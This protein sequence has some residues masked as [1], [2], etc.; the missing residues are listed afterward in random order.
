MKR[1]WGNVWGFYTTGSSKEQF[2]QVSRKEHHHNKKTLKY[3]S[4]SQKALGDDLDWV[5]G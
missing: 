2:K 3:F 5:I 1:L 4:T